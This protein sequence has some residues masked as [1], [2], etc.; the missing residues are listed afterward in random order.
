MWFYYAAGSGIYFNVGASVVF[1]DHGDASSAWGLGQSDDIVRLA[2]EATRRGYDTI[3]LTHRK[4]GIFKYEIVATRIQSPQSDG[5]FPQAFQTLFRFHPSLL[6]P[7][8]IVEFEGRIWVHPLSE[9]QEVRISGVC[10]RPKYDR[11][12]AW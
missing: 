7:T 10:D 8:S 3:Q 6:R 12:E 4:E 2:Q 1:P 5:C 11:L 9:I